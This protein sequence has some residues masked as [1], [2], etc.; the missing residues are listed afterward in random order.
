MT[1]RRFK[2]AIKYREPTYELGA[3]RK[4]E[5][6]IGGSFEIPAEDA[7]EALRI[8]LRRFDEMQ[9]L[10]SVGWV[11]EVVHVEIDLISA[12]GSADQRS[13]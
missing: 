1:S 8:A 6:F 3:G 9:K 11:R 2:I 13:R 5:P 10:S 7:V 12:H 4:P